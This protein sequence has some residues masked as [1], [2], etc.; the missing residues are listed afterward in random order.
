MKNNM[1]RF[2]KAPDD[3]DLRCNSVYVQVKWFAQDDDKQ[4]HVADED[5]FMVLAYDESLLEQ[6]DIL[7]LVDQ[8]VFVPYVDRE[9]MAEVTADAEC[10]SLVASLNDK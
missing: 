5:G 9:I 6:T 2:E 7:G 1:G 8:D 4:W 10:L 3:L